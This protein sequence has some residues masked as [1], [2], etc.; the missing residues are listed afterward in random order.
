MAN[1]EVVSYRKIGSQKLPYFLG[2][3]L[4]TKGKS[5][6]VDL[7]AEATP[8]AVDIS[9][10][11]SERDKVKFTVHTKTSLQEFQK[12]EV[13][14]VR[15]HEEFIWLHDMFE[16]A[17]EYA[18]IIIPPPPPKPD[19]DAS[20]EKLQK[21]G[22]GEGTLTK[23]EFQKMKKELEA[24]YLATFKK[25]VAMHEVFLQRIAAHPFLR[26]DVKFRVFLEYESDLNV[27]GKNKKEKLGGYFKTAVQ[28]VD[29][30]LLSNQ[31]DVDEFFEKQRKFLVTYYLRIKGATLSADQTTK[32]HKN[33]SD[34]YLKASSNL[35]ELSNAENTDI[36]ALLHCLAECFEKIRELESRVAS[37]EDLKLSDT[38]RYYLGDSAAAKHLLYRRSKA[39][40]TYE[41]A[42]KA[43]DKAR[44]KNKDVYITEKQQQEACER[45]EKLSETAREE[46]DDFKKRRIKHFKKNLTDLAEMEIKHAKA[47]TA[48]LQSTIEQLKGSL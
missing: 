9:D 11:L 23:D 32:C 21:L 14:V 1:E 22:E 27:R 42:N 37:D 34:S 15:Q 48:L 19:F 39:L 43:L 40:A 28:S 7:N 16:S 35:S 36:E 45:F 6:T 13:S 44:S 38:F 20:R 3:N 2:D 12:P 17:E 46:L 10:A 5:E 31:K 47:Q 4:F 18:G 41:N 29:E 24:E 25:T 30:V 33:V 8:I 26:K